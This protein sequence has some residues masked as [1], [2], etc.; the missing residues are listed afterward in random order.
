MRDPSGNMHIPVDPEFIW[1]GAITGIANM[2]MRLATA[3]S[4]K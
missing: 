1:R 3:D 2:S 4:L